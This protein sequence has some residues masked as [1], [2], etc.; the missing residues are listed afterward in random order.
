MLK[1]CTE[2]SIRSY[3]LERQGG[4]RTWAFK[5]EQTK[6]SFH[7]KRQRMKRSKGK[8]AAPEDFVQNRMTFSGHREIFN[9]L[10]NASPR[11][12]LLVGPP[13]ITLG[14]KT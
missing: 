6:A 12:L 7:G 11:I 5:D 10:I 9:Y 8:N 4:E 2:L 3:I 13:K 1:S 14:C